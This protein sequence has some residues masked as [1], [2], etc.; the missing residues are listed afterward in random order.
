MIG[1]GRLPRF[2][3]CHERALSVASPE[4]TSGRKYAN[5]ATFIRGGITPSTIMSPGSEFLAGP[6]TEI[7]LGVFFSAREHTS[8]PRALFRG[9]GP[10]KSGA[11]L[12][13]QTECSRLTR[14][15]FTDKE[16]RH[17]SLCQRTTYNIL[18]PKAI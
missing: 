12:E 14:G 15:T 18:Y 9:R 5:S 17:R 13:V 2:S 16:K 11:L 8:H 6:S 7:R 1:R 10:P 4:R 3:R